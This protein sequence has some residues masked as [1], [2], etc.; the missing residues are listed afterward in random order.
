MRRNGACGDGFGLPT[1]RDINHQQHTNHEG[2]QRYAPRKPI[3]QRPCQWLRDDR[4]GRKHIG[5]FGHV[6]LQNSPLVQVSETDARHHQACGQTHAREEPRPKQHRIAGGH[7]SADG[8][9]QTE[10]KPSHHGFS[11]PPMVCG[12]AHQRL[13]QAKAQCIQ[14]H[15]GRPGL[16]IHVDG[17]TKNRR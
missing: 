4:H 2:D 7:C 1:P 14:R 11:A 5:E 17:L 8:T 12:T 16:G 3:A 9:E 15:R 13:A 10:K 6:P